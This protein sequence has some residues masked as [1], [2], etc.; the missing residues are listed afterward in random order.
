M[1]S[2][3]I[4]QLS[5]AAALDGTELTPLVQGGQT[6]AAS[7]NQLAASVLATVFIGASVTVPNYATL[8]AA[9]AYIGKFAWVLNSTGFLLTKKSFRLVQFGRHGLVA[10]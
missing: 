7:I 9:S 4:S 10:R 1:T 3:K 5:A 6:R 2:L 8:P